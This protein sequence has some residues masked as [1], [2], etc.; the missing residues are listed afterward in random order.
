MDLE[1]HTADLELDRSVLIGFI[2]QYLPNGTAAKR[3]D[4]LYLGNPEG[5]ALSWLLVEANTGDAVGMSSAFPRRFLSSRGEEWGWVLGDF[6]VSRAHRSLG[7]ALRL[8]RACQ[9]RIAEG[10]SNFWYDFPSREMM[11][12]HKRLGVKRIERLVRFAKPLRL[13]R[14]VQSYVGN[15]TV[16]NAL[17]W[18]A[19]RALALAHKPS[20]KRLCTATISVL[21][22]RFGEEFT[23]LS[24]AVGSCNGVC[25]LR[26]AEYLNWRYVENPLHLHETL[27]ATVD[28]RLVAYAIFR[29]EK[30][31]IVVVD[32]FG[33]NE[34]RAIEALVDAMISLARDRKVETISV[35]MLAESSWMKIMARCGFVERDSNTVV[36][37]GGS[38]EKPDPP[39][40]GD[41]WFLMSG[42]RDL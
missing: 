42:D 38:S 32:L 34:E 35:P 6:C 14:K 4:W 2:E 5:K 36:I 39:I 8:Q 7:P 25:I 37:F 3:F 10:R 33:L 13:D 27:T 22:E 31:C 17:G 1:V 20:S 26:S 41:L 11:A 16:G 40:V 21:Q 9:E 28:G 19:N 15:N 24:Q 18:A 23:A 30:T 12:I 29:T